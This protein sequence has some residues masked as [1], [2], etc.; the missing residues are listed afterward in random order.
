MRLAPASWST[1]NNALASNLRSE[2]LLPWGRLRG[3]LEAERLDAVVAASPENVTY[4]G[5][6]WGLSHWA[7]RG[8]QVYAIAWNEPERSVDVVVPAAL[9]DLVTEP[10][11]AHSSA[12]GYG[13]FV[14]DAD[15][16]LDAGEAR[17]LAL[18]GG[19]AAEP[20][21]VLAELL[22][23]GLGGGS[24]VALESNGLAD[25]YAERLAADL[26]ELEL[27]PAERLLARCRAV[28]SPR[29]L[30]LLATAAGITE[31]GV[32][33]ALD[34]LEP[35]ATELQLARRF[36]AALV[37]DGARSETT[38]IGAGRR[39]ALPNALP[40]AR[41]V[42]PGDVVR[43]DVGCRFGHYV[44]DIARTVVVGEAGD[45]ERSLYRALSGGL[46]AAARLLRPGVPAAE[47][48]AAAVEAVRDAGLPSYARTHCGHGI[49][50]ANY[51]LPH[52]APTSADV[53]EPGMVLCL[54]TPYYRLG[55]FGLQVEDAF[56]VTDDGAE[57]LTRAPE[58]LPVAG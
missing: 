44:S 46:E 39:S 55:R 33:T 36:E 32:A 28:K 35:G 16:D 56:V 1:R 17:I 45:E 29:E 22:R 5:E 24:R 23:A 37:A 11:A 19:G 43:F 12:H 40:D 57:R 26:P 51:D 4:L 53:L 49:G 25:G 54:E 13:S 50:I 30:E 8:T 15:G 58:E 48:F 21:R 41:P 3:L 20:L 38:V 42:E 18:A 10:V 7:R 2:P 27:V 6:Y 9:A 47:L 52:V 14:L 31:R 34:G